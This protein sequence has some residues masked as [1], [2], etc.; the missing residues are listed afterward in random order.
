M[1]WEQ[2]QYLGEMKNGN[3]EDAKRKEENPSWNILW[4]DGRREIASESSEML[5]KSIKKIFVE[6]W[7]KGREENMFY[8]TKHH[9]SWN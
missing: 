5:L 1:N 6:G 9:K 8:A 7:N 4:N 2:N 3:P